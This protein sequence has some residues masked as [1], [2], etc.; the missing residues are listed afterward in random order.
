MR[1][2]GVTEF[3]EVEA[4]VTD[5]LIAKNNDTAVRPYGS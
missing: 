2:I 1:F 5:V 3:G 4:A